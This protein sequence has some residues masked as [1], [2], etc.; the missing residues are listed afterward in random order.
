MWSLTWSPSKMESFNWC[1]RK[2]FFTYY[3]NFVDYDKLANKDVDQ[4]DIILLKKL[5]AIPMRSGIIIHGIISSF[6]EQ[7]KKD[8]NYTI[9]DHMTKWFEKII[10]KK[11][12]EPYYMSAKKDYSKWYSSEDKN[13]EQKYGIVWLVEHY[14]KEIPEDQHEKYLAII[15]DNIKNS[16]DYFSKSPIYKEVK[17]NYDHYEIYHEPP[18]TDFDAMKFHSPKICNGDI[19]LFVQPDFYLKEKDSN[20]YIIVDWKSGW[21]T[22]KFDKLPDQLLAEWYRLYTENGC[23]NSMQIEW[24]F[25]NLENNCELVTWDKVAVESIKQYEEEINNQIHKLSETL[26]DNDPVKNEP[27]SMDDYP[28]TSDTKKCE[29]CS[30]RCLCI[31]K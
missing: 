25:W 3:S 15:L 2:F 9:E 1:Q 26:V 27:K 17:E 4:W 7:L 24:Y 16:I 12:R 31:K 6:F 19:D 11:I 21:S 18:K 8:K 20:K 23:D 13:D 28:M 14:Y 22:E 10:D 30:F 29:I 5:K